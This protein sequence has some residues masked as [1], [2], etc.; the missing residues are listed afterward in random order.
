MKT[1]KEKKFNLS[2]KGT[3]FNENDPNE[4]LLDELPS[5]P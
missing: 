2:N 5:S 1:K 3:F 4:V